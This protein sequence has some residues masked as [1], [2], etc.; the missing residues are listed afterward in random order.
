MWI[1]QAVYGG[2]GFFNY[3]M[4]FFEGM[5]AANNLSIVYSCYLVQT[6]D[7]EQFII[8]CNKDL[9]NTLD[10]TKIKSVGITYVFRKNSLD[11]FKYYYQY[12]VKENGSPFEI[13]YLN[14][15]LSPEKIYVPTK[16]I[17]QIKKSAK[18]GDKSSI[19]WLRALGYKSN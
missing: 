16:T 7:Y 17:S 14:N 9:F 4:S 8:P 15:E 18:K 3:D 2:N 1:F 10:L 12:N 11:N 13:M 5:A 19:Y 6:T